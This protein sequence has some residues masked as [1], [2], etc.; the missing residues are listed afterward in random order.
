MKTAPTM[1]V[2]QIF[3]NVYFLFVKA[4]FDKTGRAGQSQ[5]K[6]PSYVNFFLDENLEANTQAIAS[7]TN[8]RNS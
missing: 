3:I 6:M 5:Q 1:I 2:E 4:F 7:L 8:G